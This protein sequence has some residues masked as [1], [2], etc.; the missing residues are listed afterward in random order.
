VYLLSLAEKSRR[1]PII[2]EAGDGAVF[3]PSR[4]VIFSAHP[5]DLG[6]LGL[7]QVIANVEWQHRS[8]SRAPIIRR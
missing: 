4:A 5:A 2:A 3:S 6:Y 8:N 1:G 7:C